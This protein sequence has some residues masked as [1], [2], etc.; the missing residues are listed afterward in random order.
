MHDW[1]DHSSSGDNLDSNLMQT[2]V[3]LIWY[4]SRRS[5]RTNVEMVMLRYGGEEER[6]IYRVREKGTRTDKGM[7]KAERGMNLCMFHCR[8]GGR[9]EDE[10]KKLLVMWKILLAART[11][12]LCE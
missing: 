10:R 6:I 9:C 12:E 8:P 7:M 2:H 4:R 5:E 3:H 11:Y 1:I